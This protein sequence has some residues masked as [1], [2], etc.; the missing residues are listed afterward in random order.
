LSEG[1]VADGAVPGFFL[2]CQGFCGVSVL[3]EGYAAAGAVPGFYEAIRSYILH[4]LST[5][6]QKVSKQ[7]L[8]ESL[9]MEAAAL[10]SLVGPLSL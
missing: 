4:S 10:D 1:Y 6:C 9:R 8:S 5:T 7:V 3:R 2:P